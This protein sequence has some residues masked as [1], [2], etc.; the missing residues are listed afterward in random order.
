MRAGPKT[1]WCNVKHSQIAIQVKAL[2][3]GSCSPGRGWPPGSGEAQVCSLWAVQLMTKTVTI[4]S[5]SLCRATKSSLCGRSVAIVAGVSSCSRSCSSCPAPTPA[6]TGPGLAWGAGKAGTCMRRAEQLW[7]L[8]HCGGVGDWPAQL[9]VAAGVNAGVEGGI[10]EM[11]P[12]GLLPT[13]ALRP[14]LGCAAAKAGSVSRSC[15]LCSPDQ[16]PLQR[17][18]GCLHRTQL[19]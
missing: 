10:G 13:P 19:S 18:Q 11:G 8:R 17:K 7:S 5:S 14:V 6:Q 12:Q 2:Q 9:G 1:S 16:S 3:L 4:H 15:G